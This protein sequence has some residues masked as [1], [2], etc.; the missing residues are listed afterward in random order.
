[1]SMQVNTESWFARAREVWNLES[2][3]LSAL[4]ERIEP[5]AIA[6]TVALLDGAAR[7]ITSGAGTSGQAAR[8]IAH[9]LSCIAVPALFLS[10]ADAVHGG[11]G[12]ACPRDVA[13]LISKGG[14]TREILAL[15]PGLSSKGVPVIGVTENPDS[16]LARASAVQLIVNVDREPDQFNMLATA[17]TAS[18]IAV[19][20]AVAIVLM[21]ERG[22]TQSEFL[23]VHPAGAVGERLRHNKEQQ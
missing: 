11:L 10:P 12:V 21:E 1:M 4:G 13:V 22:F 15:L 20:D 8:K 17:S 7:V 23:S 6:K 5:A 2:A 19:F 16:E 18:V 14:N 3:A 9:T